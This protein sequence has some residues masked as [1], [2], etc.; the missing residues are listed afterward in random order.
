[1]KDMNVWMGTGRLGKDPEVNQVGSD[2]KVAN[3]SLAVNGFKE[4]DVSWVTVVCWEKLADIVAT[5]CKKGSKII[6]QGRLQTKSWETNE[7]KR[8]S[9][10]I[11]AE[12]ILI[13]SGFKTSTEKPDSG[14]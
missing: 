4:G 5:H 8:Y 11:Q 13:V 14:E 9:F 6:V 12:E 10:D 2:K 7:G 1:M 3:L